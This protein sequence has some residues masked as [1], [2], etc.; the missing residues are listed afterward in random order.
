MKVVPKFR[1]YRFAFFL[2]LV[3]TGCIK[4]DLEIC[5]PQTVRIA[6]TFIRSADCTEESISSQEVNR[7]TIFVFDENGLFVQSID[8]ISIGNNYQ[9]ELS[10]IPAHYQFVAIAGYTDDQ[11]QGK[12]LIPGV[13]HLADASIA[14]YIEEQNGSLLSAEYILHKGSDTLTVTPETPGQELTITMIQHTKVLNV[15]VD[16]LDGSELYQVA[17][18]GNAGY[19]TFNDQQFF[20]TGNPLIYVPL[21]ENED[22]FLFGR[23]LVNWPLKQ[24]GSFTRLQVINPETGYKLV[25]ENLYELLNRVPGLNLECANSFDIGFLYTVDL[26]IRIYINEWLVTENDYELQ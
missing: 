4:E 5:L 18:A 12:P 26:K 22:K 3:F 15:S 24:D 13:T 16:G 21:E 10:L 1:S 8:T 2:M 25:D 20:L 17:L 14:T 7:L 19:Y 9:M 23:S 6:F 11:L